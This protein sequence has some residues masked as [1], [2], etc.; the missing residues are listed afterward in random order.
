MSFTLITTEKEV[1][2]SD[3]VR[4]PQQNSLYK[5]LDKDNYFKRLLIQLL[6]DSFSTAS[7]RKVIIYE[8]SIINKWEKLDS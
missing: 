4:D 6:D 5:V 2:S 3:I 8:Q 1:F 7:E